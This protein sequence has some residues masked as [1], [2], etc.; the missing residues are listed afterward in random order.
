MS[1]CRILNSGR[2]G[3]ASGRAVS[4]AWAVAAVA[5]F[6][7]WQAL[8]VHYNR[9]GNWTA[10]FLSGQ[11]FPIPPDLARGTYRFPG[12]GYDGQM[13]RNVAHDPFMQRGYA[14][15]LD[16][17]AE[18]YHRI[19]VPA[20]AYLLATGHQ[21]RIDVSYIAVIALFAFLGA[22]W[23]GQWA[24]LAAMNPAWSLAFLLVPATLI[25]MDRLTVDI[26]LAALC[27]GFAVYW[28]TAS[29]AALF[30]VLA[31]A[32]LA[33]ETGLLLVAGVCLSELLQRRFARALGWAFAAL[34]M[35][36]W[37]LLMQRRVSEKSSIGLLHSWLVHW[38]AWPFALLRHPPRY[39]LPHA[40]ELIA[41]S[42]DVVALMAIILASVL[43]F[44]LLRA[45]SL[46]PMAISAAIFGALVFVL[47]PKGFWED[48]NGYA[49]VWS[50]L[51]ILI[52]LPSVAR[53]TNARLPWWMGLV[54]LVLVD[55][56][57]GM[58]FASPTGNIV[59]GILTLR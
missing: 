47:T 14:H 32:C 30:M 49:R 36:G 56:R 4:A 21:S 51:L 38:G 44:L 34:P 39:P 18:R 19:L 35:F 7:L 52:A 58:Q 13:Y 20:L 33:R 37:Y 26:A 57:L 6:I 45:Q 43:A 8:T 2:K 40:L 50:P 25:S 24:A 53:V 48:V 10:L 42:G 1:Y 54:P 17:P 3:A 41:R 55:L 31:S 12:L 5:V 11:D 27:V 15:Y 9:G 28:R 22:Y 29:W 23:L 46:T 16:F 59:H